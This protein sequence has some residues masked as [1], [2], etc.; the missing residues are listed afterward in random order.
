MK[1]P[2]KKQNNNETVVHNGREFPTLK[3]G[4][5]HAVPDKAIGD[6][7]VALS[8]PHSGIPQ[9]QTLSSRSRFIALLSDVYLC[10]F[11]GLY[12]VFHTPLANQLHKHIFSG[13]R[14]HHSSRPYSTSL[15]GNLASQ[16][17]NLPFFLSFPPFCSLFLRHTTVSSRPPASHRLPC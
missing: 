11:V 2:E 4:V 5:I 8:P 14:L 6:I 3:A 16:V 17:M 7:D 13:R 1:T 15:Y 10:M 12:F 9:R